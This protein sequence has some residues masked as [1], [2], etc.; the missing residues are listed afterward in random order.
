MKLRL[1]PN[2]K[3]KIQWVDIASF[4]AWQ[5]RD[6]I[7]KI[8]ETIIESVYIY[9]GRGKGGLCFAG[10]Y[11]GEE[12]GNVTIVPRGNIKKITLIK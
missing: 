1:L 9:V 11:N 6:E 2:K 12:Y 3:Y 10:E 4:S 5:H 7:L 8:P